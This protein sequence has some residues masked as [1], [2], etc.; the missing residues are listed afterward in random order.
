MHPRR[1]F[2]RAK[3]EK[4]NRLR[5]LFSNAITSDEKHRK[6][7]RPKVYKHSKRTIY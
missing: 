3:R 6:I 7:N 1:G 2:G 4:S 5:Y